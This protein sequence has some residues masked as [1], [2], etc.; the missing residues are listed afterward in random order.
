MAIF[1]YLLKPSLRKGLLH[2]VEKVFLISEPFLFRYKVLSKID[3]AH[4]LWA[5][6]VAYTYSPKDIFF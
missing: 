6:L 1:A 4:N 5:L 3:D 2:L